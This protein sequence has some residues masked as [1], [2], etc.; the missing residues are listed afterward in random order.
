M[1]TVL[2]ADD[3]EA[4][5]ETFADIVSSLGHRVLLAHDGE[6]ALVLAKSATPDVILSDYMM[7]RRNGTELLKEL[8]KDP[9]LAQV[10]FILVSATK[11]RGVEEAW[12]FLP[13]PLNLETLE[14][15]I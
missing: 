12:K 1:R 8:Q 7:P 11:P 14:S 3:E 9:A 10:P 15:T 4:L 13:K 5:L 2:L 6:E